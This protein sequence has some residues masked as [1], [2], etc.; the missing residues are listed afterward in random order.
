MRI[1]V[2]QKK[3]SALLV[4][5]LLLLVSACAGMSPA[6]NRRLQAVVNRAVAIDMPLEVAVER[7]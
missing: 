7:L 1:K 5:S 2:E 3:I 6:D 4:S